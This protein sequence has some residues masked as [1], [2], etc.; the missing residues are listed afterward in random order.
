MLG[1][2]PTVAAPNGLRISRRRDAPGDTA[3]KARLKSQSHNRQ[4]KTDGKSTSPRDPTQAPSY[5]ERG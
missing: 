1:S 3:G 4:D 5:S 2:R